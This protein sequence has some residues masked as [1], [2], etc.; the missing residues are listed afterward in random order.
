MAVSTVPGD[1]GIRGRILSGTAVAQQMKDELKAK[2]TAAV[3]QGHR[4]PSLTVILVGANPASEIYVRNKTKACEAVG[5][6]ST[7]VKFAAD[8]TEADLLAEIYRINT[9]PR[10]DGLIVQLPL[11]EHLSEDTIIE[12]IDADKDVDGFH[13]L[14]VGRLMQRVPAIRP[15][16]PQG[17]MELIKACKVN[18]YGLDALVCGASNIV[19]RPMIME[20]LLAGCTVTVCHR[21]TRDLEAKV[22]VADIVVAAAGKPGLI[23]GEWIKDG[24]IVIDVGINRLADGSIVGD[25]EFEKA[26]E[27]A[28]FITPVPGGVGP[29]T[30]ATLLRN[31][32]LSYEMHGMGAGTMRARAM[33]VEEMMM[34]RSD[35]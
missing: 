6:D 29:M 17:V 23:K 27:R 10:V 12:A 16:T 35:W 22:R 18:T 32:L 4:R 24:A 31:T 2:V 14:N 28:S 25:V 13:P 20:L 8:I 11:P 19:G 7:L 26:K 15:A 5:I 21:F 30:V 9:D 3:D 33:S 34:D 1:D